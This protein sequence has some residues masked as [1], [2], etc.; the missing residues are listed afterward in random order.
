MA[1]AQVRKLVQSLAF[2]GPI[3]SLYPLT[4]T[5][6]PSALPPPS[7]VFAR[8]LSYR[9]H[10][11]RCVWPPAD[12]KALETLM[13]LATGVTH[14]SPADERRPAASHHLEPAMPAFNSGAPSCGAHHA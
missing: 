6:D 5:T 13:Q 2:I 9:P 14:T 1:S 7:P 10:H 4:N 12:W 8:M 3:V 11:T